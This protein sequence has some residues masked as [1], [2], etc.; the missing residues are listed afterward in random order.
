[1]TDCF[2]CSG[3]VVKYNFNDIEFEICTACNTVTI[4]KNNFDKLCEKFN[5]NSKSVDFFNIP[6]VKS[7]EELYLAVIV[8]NQQKKF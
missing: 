1:M 7:K 5:A 3:K 6:S 4:S 8:D 2:K